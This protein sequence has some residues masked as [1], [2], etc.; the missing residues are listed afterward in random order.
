MAYIDDELPPKVRPG[1]HTVMLD[2]WST[3]LMFQGKAPKLICIFAIVSSGEDHGKR[4]PR[5]YNVKRI[6][7]KPSVR[8]AFQ[9]TATGDFAR[10]FYTLTNYGGRRLDRLP[11]TLLEGLT[12]RC[13][14]ETV[15]SARGREIPEP[16]QYSKI[17]RLIK[18]VE[19]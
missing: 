4:I 18:V 12:I 7:G 19:E 15:T 10:E 14:I 17:S 3:A 5:Y 16:L 8:G 6:K 13:E 11:M 1:F 2:S 9:A